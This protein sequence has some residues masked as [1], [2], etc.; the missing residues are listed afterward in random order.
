MHTRQGGG[1]Q[2]P[3]PQTPQQAGCRGAPCLS[4]CCGSYH[5]LSVD[6]PTLQ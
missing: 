5:A 4:T 3:R 1:R 6:N 2:Q